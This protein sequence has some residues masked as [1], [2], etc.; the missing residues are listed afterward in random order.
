MDK[1][2]SLYNFRRV[3]ITEN[4]GCKDWDWQQAV[5]HFMN[6][7][8]SDY[9]RDPFRSTASQGRPAVS[10][11]PNH[12][13]YEIVIPNQPS[14]PPIPVCIVKHRLAW[15]TGR[16]VMHLFAGAVLLVVVFGLGLNVYYAL[17]R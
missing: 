17:V 13:T 6:G 16:D 3:T 11:Q 15:P 1:R 5:S 4:R 9:D 14:R 7:G 2:G 10:Y 8:Q 12:D